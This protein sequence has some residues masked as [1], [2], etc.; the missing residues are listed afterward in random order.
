MI[1]VVGPRLL[2]L[3][4]GIALIRT[5]GSPSYLADEHATSSLPQPEAH[6][7]CPGRWWAG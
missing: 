4:L 1:I 3:S 7:A 2:T 6:S 5:V